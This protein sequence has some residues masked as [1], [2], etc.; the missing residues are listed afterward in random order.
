LSTPAKTSSNHC[1]A[2]V[3]KNALKRFEISDHHESFACVALSVF[4][5]K[6]GYRLLD[7]RTFTQAAP[8]RRLARAEFA[9]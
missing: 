9:W 7:G 6:F 4:N 3:K 8:R 5:P 1:A 2:A